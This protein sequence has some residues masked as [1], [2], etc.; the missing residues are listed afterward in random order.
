MTGTELVANL[1]AQVIEPNPAF[2]TST[3]LLNLLNAGQ[4]NYVRR[5]RVLQNFAT[6]SSVQ[7]QADYPMPADWLGSEKVFYNNVQN[8][9]A[10]WIPLIPTSLEKM[11]QE[12]P[13]FLSG[14][15]TMQ[16]IPQK[17]Y[18]VN[19][20]LFVY[21][22][23]M[24]SGSNDIFMFY[25]SKPVVL[26]NLDEELSI[27]DS[28]TEGLEAYMLWRMYKMDQETE[29]AKEEEARYKDEIGEGRKWKKKRVL[30]GKWKIDIQSFLPFS[31]SSASPAGLN[32]LNPLNM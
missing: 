4:K 21:P 18:I 5:T 10:S 6:T 16:G 17:Y 9:V 1:R 19:Q 30:D 7:G 12:S 8:G 15:S 29:L 27:D 13:N 25:E 14:D 11:S 2:F 28:L 22:R 26:E 31:Y 23:P 3:A 32:G 20:T 24:S